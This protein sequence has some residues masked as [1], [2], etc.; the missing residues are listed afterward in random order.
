MVDYGIMTYYK[1]YNY[2]SALQAYALYREVT[3]LGYSCKMLDYRPDF[4]NSCSP[5]KKAIGIIKRLFPA[6]YR[7]VFWGWQ[8]K[9]KKERFVNFY[10]NYL[11]ESKPYPSKEALYLAQKEYRG[12]ICGSD[13]IWT[14]TPNGY[15]DAYVLSFA[16]N[17][18][19]KVA[20]APSIGYPNILPLYR[21]TMGKGIERFDALSIR[22][23]HGAEIIQKLTGKTAEVVLDPTFLLTREDWEQFSKAP[24][25][26]GPYIFCY[27]LGKRQEARILAKKLKKLTGYSLIIA[28]MWNR[29]TL[30]ADQV[31]MDIGPQEFIGLIQ[32]AAYVC[33]DSY[34][35]TILSINLNT[36][37]YTFSRHTE[38]D[39]E[40]QNL[41]ITEILDMFGLR[42]RYLESA[43]KLI[44]PSQV[45]FSSVNCKLNKMRKQSF[46]YLQR[47][48]IFDKGGKEK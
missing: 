11:K 15:D 45:N 12:I 32:N 43:T 22:E 27:F 26:K 37:F 5:L 21:E 38:H 40:N 9:L 10:Q 7:R 20:Y 33:T 18:L 46:A 2:G 28:P 47:A 48:L 24:L 8:F 13:Q 34:H 30:W 14:P 44:C 35:A 6:F 31:R 29:D 19:R 3:A 42:E 16:D 4:L 41:R 1:T 36:S 25:Q 23:P 39:P 17:D